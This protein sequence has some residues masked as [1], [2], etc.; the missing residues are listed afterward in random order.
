MT[1]R[2]VYQDSY[3]YHVHLECDCSHV[4][5]CFF[6]NH[7]C[8][9]DIYVDDDDENDDFDDGVDEDGLEK[10]LEENDDSSKLS[11]RLL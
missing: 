7:D 2:A 6:T 5:C 3:S 9:N 11:Q 1:T 10:V 8:A 4:H